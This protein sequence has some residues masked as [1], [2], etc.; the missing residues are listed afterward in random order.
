MALSLIEDRRRFRRVNDRIFI[1]CQF[2]KKKYVDIIKGFSNDLSAGGLCFETDRFISPQAIFSLEIYQPLRQ[3]KEE[4][5]TVFALAK[6]KWVTQTD[7][8]GKYEGSNK[9]IIGVEFVEV[10]NRERKA[11]AEYVQDKLNI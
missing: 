3:S 5:I 6:A 11:I 1:L 8:A 9:Y 7:I 4:L 10:D 2:M